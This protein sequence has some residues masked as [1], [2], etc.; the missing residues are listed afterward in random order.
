[1]TTPIPAAPIPQPTPKI[2]TRYVIVSNVQNALGDYDVFTSTYADARDAA[3]DTESHEL[4]YTLIAPSDAA[5]LQRLREAEDAAAEHHI[6]D[7]G[8]GTPEEASKSFD[9]WREAHAARIAF[10]KKIGG[11][12]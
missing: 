3:L 8:L 7:V 2:G 1:M 5:E 6:E 10:E 12:T 4:V 9:V 11:V